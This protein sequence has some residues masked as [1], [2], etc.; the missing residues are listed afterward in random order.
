MSFFLSAEA[1]YQIAEKNAN[2]SLLKAISEIYNLTTLCN[3]TENYSFPLGGLRL[4]WFLMKKIN[5]K[6][7]ML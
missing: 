3:E 1:K 2:K 5:I 7:L 4:D 6:I